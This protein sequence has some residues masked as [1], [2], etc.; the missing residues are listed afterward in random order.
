V[1]GS[2]EHSYEP[3][4]SVTGGEFPDYQSDYSPLEKDSAP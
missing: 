2:C 1:A 4:G 3:S